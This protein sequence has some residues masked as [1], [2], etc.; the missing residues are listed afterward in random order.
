M[1]FS[2]GPQRGGA[3]V[4]AAAAVD[5]AY[6]AALVVAVPVAVASVAMHALLCLASG[7]IL[8][9]DAMSAGD[10]A[11]THPCCLAVYESE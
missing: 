5:A 9:L 4:A 10:G 3:A 8:C 11:E 2:A 6:A 7:V 1:K